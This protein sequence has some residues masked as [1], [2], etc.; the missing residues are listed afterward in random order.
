MK[1]ITLVLISALLLIFLIGQ[2]NSSSSD[3]ANEQ[4]LGYWS[5]S[6]GSQ[7]TI[8]EFKEDGTFQYTPPLEMVLNRDVAMGTYQRQGSQVL[9]RSDYGNTDGPCYFIFGKYEVE[10][11]GS[12]RMRLDIIENE[13]PSLSGLPTNALAHVRE[14]RDP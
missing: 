1:S 10:M 2:L 11:I 5:V 12:S 8:I 13:C 14:R 7:A 9:L 6:D 3:N 4:L